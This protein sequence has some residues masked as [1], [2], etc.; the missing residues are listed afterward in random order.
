MRKR[1]LTECRLFVTLLRKEIINNDAEYVLYELPYELNYQIGR[2]KDMNFSA[3]IL[4]Y[5]YTNTHHS[6][7]H[8]Q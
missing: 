2:C 4:V 3:P 6:H 7:Y 5:R 1:Q 8:V